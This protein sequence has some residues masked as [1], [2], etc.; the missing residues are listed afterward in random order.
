VAVARDRRRRFG[1]A[2]PAGASVVVIPVEFA[3]LAAAVQ[4]N[5]DRSDARHAQD[6]TLCTYLLEMRELYRWERAAPFGAPLPQAE[7]SAWIAA[8]EA[9]WDEVAEDDLAPLPVGDRAFDPYDVDAVND[10]L[11][12][13]GLVYGAGIGRFGKPQFFLADLL[14]DEEA[15][16]C[17]VLVAGREHARDLSGE[18]GASRGGTIYVRRESLT[19]WLWERAEGWR[20]H[21]RDGALQAALAAYGFGADPAAAMA[22]MVD[23]EESVIVLHEQ[24]ECRAAALLGPGWEGLLSSLSRRR[25]EL[26]VRAVRDLLADCLTTLPALLA[27]DRAA[28]SVHFWFAN[29]QGMRRELFPGA[30]AAY[31]RWCAGENESLL[32][33]VAAGAAHWQR[34]AERM[35]ACAASAGAAPEDALDA[36]A[37][38]AATRL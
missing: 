11:A 32:A 26:F 6:L 37:A 38:E 12:G 9:R 19:R 31:A 24:G 10:A 36:L 8:R 21:R 29:L 23:G 28:G 34:V 7:V 20:A 17:H 1:L 4:A 18:P 15:N 13:R 35:L 33:A 3:P 27:D 16:G 2:P 5:C 25:T 14:R 22:A 30:V